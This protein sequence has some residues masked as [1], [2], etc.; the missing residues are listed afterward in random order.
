MIDVTRY[1]DWMIHNVPQDPNAQLGEC[2][3]YVPLMHAAF[4]ELTLCRGVVSSPTNLDN[5]GAVDKQYPHMWLKD[6][7]GAIYD[8]TVLQFCRLG[9]LTYEEFDPKATSL[10]RCMNCGRY[11]TG[12]GTAGSGL[13]SNECVREYDTY[14]MTDRNLSRG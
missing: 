12:S 6:E 14:V 9:E 4:P 2:T 8:P 11:F 10:A 3:R 13:C 7:A 1:F 5:F